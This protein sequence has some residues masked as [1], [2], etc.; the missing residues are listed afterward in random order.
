MMMMFMGINAWA[1]EVVYKTALFGVSYNSKAVSSYTTSFTA[2]N[3]D[4]TVNVVN[5]NNNNNGWD[6]VKTGN[7]S[8]ASVGSI[9]TTDAI[10][11]AV[12]KVV[13]TID[14]VTSSSV[15]SIKL[16]SGTSSSSIT[17]DEGSF[18]VQTGE[19]A[20]TISSP[21]ADKYYKLEF[22]C[23]KGSSNGL[24]TVS[25]VEFYYNDSDAPTVTV[26]APK[27]DVAAG[28]YT[29]DQLVL[30]D[31]YNNNYLYFYTTDG[32]TPACDE[33]LDA[34]GTSQVYEHE[35]GIE[36]TET[37]TLKMIAV[38]EDGNTSSV[39]SAAYVINKPIV[40]ASLEELV[41][42][43]ITTGTIVS[44]SFENVPIKSF[45]TNSSNVR[46]GLFFDIQKGGKDIEIYYYGVPSE[47]EVGGTLS[48]TM[49]CPWKLYGETWELAPA[50]NSWS[51]NNLTYKAPVART[52]TAI[53]VSGTPAKTTYVAGEAL[54]PKGL[55]V[56]GTYNIGEPSVITSGIEWTFNPETLS[57]GATTCDVMA[58]VGE[59]LSDVYIVTGLTVMA[60]KA[61]TTI[62]LTGTPSKTTY[63]KGE[64]FSTAGLGVSAN[65]NYG[66]PEDVTANATFEVT[67]ATFEEVGEQKVTVVAKYEDK[68]VSH[69][70]TV[71][72]TNDSKVTYEFSSFTSNATVELTDFDGFVITLSKNEGSTNP[73]WSSNQAR[74]YAK[75]S[76]TVKANNAA[77]TSIAYDY[78]VNKN[79]NGVAPTIDR[80][81]GKTDDGIWDADAKTWTGSDDEVTF[82]TSGSAG[83]IGFT[84]LTITYAKSNKVETSLAWSAEEATVTINASDN[85]FPTLTV[86]PADLE[87]VMYTSSNTKA[88]TIDETTGL[89]TLVAPGKTEIT[90]SYAGDATH[91][92]STA[93]YTL[94]VNKAPFVPVPVEDGYEIVNFAALSP[95]KDLETNGSADMRDYE[96]TSFAMA[97]AKREGTNNAPKYYENGNAVRAYVGNKVTITAAEPIKDVDV[98]W[99]SGYIDNAVSIEGVGTTTAVITF[100]KTCRFTHIGVAY[101]TEA[102]ITNANGVASYVTSLPA[103][104]T[105]VEG[106]TAYLCTETSSETVTLEKAGKVPAGTALVVV[107]G[108]STSY[109]LPFTASATAVENL[110]LAGEYTVQEGDFVYA[111][112]TQGQFQKV[113]TGVTIPARKAYL[114]TE[115]ALSKTISIFD[116]DETT[117]IASVNNEAVKTTA[118][119]VI[120]NG[121]LRIV[122][123]NGMF[124]TTG[125]QVK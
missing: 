90:A 89:I 101:A 1:E 35:E 122:T 74:V 32:T 10:D 37:C 96:G 107:G 15:N 5:F 38:D 60:P 87:G 7:K 79:K 26:T 71:N 53:T 111:L 45:Y 3:D 68:T 88:A 94:T 46:T 50:S 40:F 17:T 56:T 112:N 19:N 75:G 31:N 4:F 22:D 80:V 105:N 98:A 20:V 63:C 44:V 104:F 62:E 102:L 99:V 86:T 114:K 119:K 73:T 82:S 66:D 83:N 70:Y 2:T 58:N 9:T 8:N 100:S 106:L 91:T 116:V 14:A 124:T 81:S 110:F 78:V 16:Y 41:D 118:R 6:Y 84:S 21:G 67:P 36:I 55:V 117:G 42:A 43:D 64:A 115:E 51:W 76:L 30:V 95:Y 27:F 121:Q 11:K 123:P 24:V 28:T 69:E 93:S 120:V 34:T 59:V 72:V 39:T 33:N 13:L 47:W 65:Y 52:L 12:T 125:A 113:G 57:E 61:L 85:I 54:D 108:K 29:E 109:D 92:S 23:K 97:F 25:K 48:G 103:D 49:T 77:I 18:D